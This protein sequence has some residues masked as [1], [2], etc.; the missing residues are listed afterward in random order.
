MRKLLPAKIR[1]K[2]GRETVILPGQRLDPDFLTPRDELKRRQNEIFK[3]IEVTAPS[4]DREPKK[5]SKD[6][7]IARSN[8][9]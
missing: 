5:E 2:D 9:A 8:A 6:R 4:L 7:R 3:K 1:S